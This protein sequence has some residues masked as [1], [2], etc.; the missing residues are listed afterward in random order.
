MNSIDV[1]VDFSFQGKHYTPEITIDLDVYIQQKE[2]T[3]F[4]RLIANK[5]E[6]D[7]YSY[8]Y[9]IMESSDVFFR[10]PQ[11]LAIAYTQDDSFNML[12]YVKQWKENK[13]VE[14]LLH[15]A[16]NEM[17]IADFSDNQALKNALFQ[18]YELGSYSRTSS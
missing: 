18:A 10:N 17:D 14:Q 7:C 6:I 8:L 13:L 2:A 12:S 3:S 11:G 5:H 1:S 15:I 4:H 9:E 16:K